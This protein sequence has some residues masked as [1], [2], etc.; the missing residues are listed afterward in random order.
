MKRLRENFQTP[1][2]QHV[3]AAEEKP[4]FNED[5][6]KPPVLSEVFSSLEPLQAYKSASV[7]E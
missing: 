4:Y 5:R 7:S 3:P 2:P 1:V 6:Y